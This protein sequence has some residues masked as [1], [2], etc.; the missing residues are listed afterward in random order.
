[1]RSLLDISRKVS[2]LETLDEIL[3]ELIKI[4]TTELD[5]DRGTIFLNDPETGELYS[6]VAQGNFQREIRLLNTS[7]IAGTVFQT[8]KSL[9]IHDAYNDDRFNQSVDA[10]TGYVTKSILYVPIRAA[11][12]ESIGVAQVL[13][14]KSGPF[15]ED[16]VMLLEAIAT[17]AAIALQ[18][19]IF[20]ERMKKFR[21]K[22]MQFLMWSR[23][24]HRKSIWGISCIRSCP[25]R[26]G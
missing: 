24:R 4:T 10:K 15:T 16:D 25:R 14:K 7:G 11:R 3:A 6:R 22:E 13:N 5:A 9:I 8:G 12:N 21:T 1:M 18:S 17:Q 26:C 20:T 2:T 19:T 23:R